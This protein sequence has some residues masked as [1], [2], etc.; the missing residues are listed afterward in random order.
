MLNLAQAQ[1]AIISGFDIDEAVLPAR[2]RR[3]TG[4]R[5]L[6]EVYQESKQFV[7]EHKNDLAQAGDRARRVEA[8]ANRVANG[9]PCFAE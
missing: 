2:Y 6:L 5:S 9:L 7:R 3:G 4:T 8:L 1:L